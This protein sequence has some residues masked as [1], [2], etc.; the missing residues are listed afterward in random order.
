MVAELAA[1]IAFFVALAAEALHWRRTRRIAQLA[2]GPYTTPRL[3]ARWA[4]LFTAFSVAAVVWGLTTLLFIEPKTHATT[5]IADDEIKHLVLVLDVSP[6][7][8]L[9]DAGP[10]AKQSRR[11]RVHSL[12]TSFF[13][14]VQLPNYRTSIVA[15]YNGAKPVVIDTKDREVVNNVLEDLPLHFA[16]NAGKTDLFAGLGEAAGIVKEFPPKTT[17]LMLLSDGDTVPATGMPEMPDSVEH[18]IVVGVGDPVTGKFL[19]GSQSRQDASTLRQIAMRLGGVYH[20]GNEK[21]LSTD[22]IRSIAAGETKSVFEKLSKREFA[23]LACGVGA[24][25]LA[26]L[27]LLLHYFGTAWRPGVLQTSPSG[28][29]SSPQVRR[30]VHRRTPATSL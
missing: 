15:V 27:P 10:D 25:L 30:K 6:S 29:N 16:F 26:V 21:H 5:T 20:D 7:M 11:Q 12:M 19:N 2:F 13:D 4:P 22:L 8:F 9:V 3:W 28:A 14:R 17:T 1:L 24:A 23:L 18:V